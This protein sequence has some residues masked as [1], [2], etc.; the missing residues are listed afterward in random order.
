MSKVGNR[1]VSRELFEAG[2]CYIPE[3]SVDNNNMM[4]CLPYLVETDCAELK[5]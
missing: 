4:I 2:K 5:P 3:V 1:P